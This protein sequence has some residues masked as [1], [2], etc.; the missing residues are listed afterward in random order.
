MQ[1]WLRYGLIGGGASAVITAI[2]AVI[3]FALSTGN[4]C[5]RHSP[6]TIGDLGFIIFLGLMGY[7][8]Y[9]SARAGQSVGQG[10]LAGL[11]AAL[12]SGAG[13][14]VAFLLNLPY[15]QGQIACVAGSLG[16]TNGVDLTAAGTSL[17]VIA[18][19]IA[20]LLGMGI[21]AGAAAIGALIG[22]PA[23]DL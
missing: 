18:L 13:T 10:S 4:A 8:G 6:R 15:E 16:N 7:V 23:R 11:T 12:L 19:I 14:V 20:I 17:G 21:G 9:A 22:R 2:L 3:S 5:N 1:P